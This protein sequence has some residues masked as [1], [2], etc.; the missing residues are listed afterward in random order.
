MTTLQIP[1]PELVKRYQAGE[2]PS[3]ARATVTYEDEG[4]TKPL[5]PALALIEEWLSQAPTDPDEIRA[6]EEDLQ[7]FQK[8]LNQTR[9]EAGARILYP[10]VEES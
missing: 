6:A 10:S 8:A 2:I 4:E 5:D 1:V 9:K 3:S 7:A